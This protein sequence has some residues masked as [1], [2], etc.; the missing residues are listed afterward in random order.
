MIPSWI[1][2]TL[3]CAFS[4]A[5]SDALAKRAL[6]RHDEYLFLWLRL[7]LASP[8]L[9][10]TLFFVPIPAP[11]PGFYRA[12]FMALPLEALA[13]VLYIRALKLSPLSLTLPLLALTPAFLLAVPFLLLGERISV[14]GT[15]GVILIATGTYLLNL[16]TAKKGLLEPLRAIMREKGARCMLGVALLYSITST[17]GKQAIAASSPLFFAAIYIPLLALLLTPLAL[18]H[19]QGGIREIFSSGAMREALLPALFYALMVLTHMSAIALTRVA[20]MISVKRLSLLMGV[21]YGHVLFKEEGVR[22]RVAATILMLCGMA[23]ITL[24]P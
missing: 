9:L 11:A 3:L 15:G 23:L 19:M 6:A 14:A 1:P 20:Y 17:L 24:Y 5:T 13:S 18:R 4:L 8:F 7:L 21:I 12:M 10:A 2:L 22:G 16:G